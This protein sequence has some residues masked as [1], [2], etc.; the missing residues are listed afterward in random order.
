MANSI[1]GST[2]GLAG[3]LGDY[4]SIKNG[5][6]GKLMKKYYGTTVS[7]S[8]SGDGTKTKGSS[9]IL[10]KILEEKRNP[11]VSQEAEKANSTLTSSVGL[12][13]N[14]VSTLQKAD[15]FEDQKENNNGS[16]SST[17]MEKTVS[18]LK[19]FVASYNDALT[20]SKRSTMTN[21]SSNIAGIMKATE[22]NA[23]E[24]KEIGITKNNDGTLNF[25]E[26]L[27]S[28]D[29]LDKVKELFSGDDAMSYGSAVASRL[30]RVSVYDSSAS[31][32]SAANSA[33]EK[34]ETSSTSTS[35]VSSL[36]SLMSDKLD[37][38]GMLSETK[39]FIKFYNATLDSA[40]KSG[41]S[42]VTSN[43]L[44]MRD[45]TAKHSGELSKLGI[46][47]GADGK[48]SM[49]EN[50]FKSAGL[51]NIQDTFKKYGSDI[52]TN[53]SLLNYYSTSGSTPQSSYSSNGAYTSAND[54][55]SSL[56]NA[57]G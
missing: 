55:V 48:L 53:A 8:S 44:A 46:T 1:F 25:N 13:K 19:N 15:T 4:N 36:D 11:K 35:L 27:L 51:S 28:D 24:L 33:K 18:A 41:V 16:T 32:S 42:G 39:N 47:Q 57:K 50:T 23:E 7:G 10:E 31:S 54:I 37:I 52:R 3:V 38:E 56:Y 26:K 14:A 2:D 40:A 45:K 34:A 6:Y 29:E 43:L 22:A 21:V 5:T 17:G 49:N 12:L 30:N 9:G 20:A